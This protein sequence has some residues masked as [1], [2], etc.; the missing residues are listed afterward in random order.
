M[1]P[2]KGSSGRIISFYVLSLVTSNKN[3]YDLLYLGHGL[4]DY[5][6]FCPRL[7][8]S[9]TQIYAMVGRGISLNVDPAA[10]VYAPMSLNANHSPI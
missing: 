4:G 1:D 9:L 3:D 6:G 8:D 5:I 7:S 10:V 2:T